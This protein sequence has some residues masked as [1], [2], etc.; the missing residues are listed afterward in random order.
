MDVRF[1]FFLIALMGLLVAVVWTFPRWYPLLNEETIAESFPGLEIEAQA[2]F[3]ALPQAVQNALLLM[4][5]GDEDLELEPRPE[6]ALALVRARL[7][8]DDVVSEQSLNGALE[9][10]SETALRDGSFRTL[11]PLRQAEGEVTVYQRA[12]LSRVLV[13][14]EDF[15]AMRAPDVHVILTNNPDPL[16]AIGVG[17]DYID[18]GELK[19]NVGWQTYEIPENVD[20]SVYPILVLYSVEYDYVISTATL[21]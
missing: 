7:L 21:S 1:R 20:F 12:D 2:S 18:L 15:R 11:D 19:G 9:P 8:Q 6:L 17:G 16:D 5:N 10:P 4:R 14:G 13:I 3:L